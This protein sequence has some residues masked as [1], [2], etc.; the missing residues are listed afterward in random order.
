L[1]GGSVP[2]EFDEDGPA[3][4]TMAA[5]VATELDRTCEIPDR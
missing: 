4:A 3:V 1:G 5:A 2:L